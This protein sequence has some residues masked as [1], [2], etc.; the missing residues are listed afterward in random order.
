VTAPPA[1][2]LDETLFHK[3]LEKLLEHKVLELALMLIALT[4]A[5]AARRYSLRAWAQASTAAE[6]I[7]FRSR[8]WL[9]RVGLRVVML[10]DYV[11]L[12]ESLR[13]RL[14]SY[15]AWHERQ[16]LKICVFTMQLPRDWPLWSDTSAASP[17]KTA[18]E[19]YFFNFDAFLKH[20]KAMNRPADV[21]RIIII[22]KKDSPEGRDRLRKLQEDVAA[23][24]FDRYLHMLHIDESRARY[25]LHERPWPGWLTDAVFYGLEGEGG[26]HWLWAVTTSYNAGEDL[27]LLRFH[28]MRG[29]SISRRFA[30]PWGTTSLV[31]LVDFLAEVDTLALVSLRGGP[32]STDDAPVPVPSGATAPRQDS[33][34]ASKN[35][36]KKA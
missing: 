23:P 34:P 3:A 9:N 21:T 4:A 33:K 20:T 29:R 27:L 1:P 36:R 8:V 13:D 17:D 16:S 25:Y 10:D 11:A 2:P 14:V 24:L 35:R 19:Q 31:Q 15:C 32:N 5:F 30:L 22:E 6:R 12:L 18:L 7:G 26:T 28:R